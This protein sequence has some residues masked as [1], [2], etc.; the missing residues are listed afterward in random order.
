MNH[1]NANKKRISTNCGYCGKEMTT[2]PSKFKYSKS[3]KV[4]C[5]N[6]CVGKYNSIIRKK[7]INKICLVCGTNYEVI[8]SQAEKSVTC[9]VECQHIWQSKYLVGENANNYKHGKY[10]KS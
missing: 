4:F 9:S 2:T 3:G 1:L 10:V 5:S 7:R 8:P 6:K